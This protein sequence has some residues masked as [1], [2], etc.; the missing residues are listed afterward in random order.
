MGYEKPRGTPL[1]LP[2]LSTHGWPEA[3]AGTCCPLAL[4]QLPATPPS[5]TFLREVL[6]ADCKE[7]QITQPKERKGDSTKY[8][9]AVPRV[10]VLV[11]RSFAAWC[12]KEML[13]FIKISF[14][15]PFSHTLQT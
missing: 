5:R 4:T 12:D 15:N 7:N 11:P 2:F 10:L 13:S 8:T 1:F 9:Q 6:P 14:R 3:H